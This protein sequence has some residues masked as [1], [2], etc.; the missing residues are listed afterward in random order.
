LSSSDGELAAAGGGAHEET[1]DVGAGEKEQEENRAR[2][3]EARLGRSHENFSHGTRAPLQP[4]LV[5]GCA[6]ARALAMASISSCASGSETPGAMRAAA[7]RK[8]QSRGGPE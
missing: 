6:A 8:R 7:R 1:S 3:D 4:R 2:E 5:A